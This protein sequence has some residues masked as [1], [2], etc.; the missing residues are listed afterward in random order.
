MFPRIPHG[1]PPPVYEPPPGYGEPPPNI[2]YMLVYIR[3]SAV[4]EVLAPF[5]DEDTPHLSLTMNG[6]RERRR[7]ENERNNTYS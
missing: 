7:N 2:S 5:T 4:K 3:E 1:T 6:F